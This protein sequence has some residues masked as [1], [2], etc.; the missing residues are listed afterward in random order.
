M[1]IW[2]YCDFVPWHCTVFERISW[3]RG[4]SKNVAKKNEKKMK[5]LIKSAIL[6]SA[7]FHWLHFVLAF[8]YSLTF[9]LSHLISLT[10]S[11]LRSS[12][13]RH[14]LCFSVTFNLSI[15][16]PLCE[17]WWCW[18]FFFSVCHSLSTVLPLLLGLVGVFLL[19]R[20]FSFF[21]SYFCLSFS[22]RWTSHS[23]R[24]STLLIF[25]LY[26]YTSPDK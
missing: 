19:F 7:Y 12:P 11:F 8:A 3:K 23:L 9:M 20:F 15:F 18:Y 5:L 1:M 13:I 4:W 17:Q 24:F 10:S 16:T 21:C 26:L 14:S 25:S 2:W 22:I 6:D